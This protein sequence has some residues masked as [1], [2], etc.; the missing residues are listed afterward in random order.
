MSSLPTLRVREK[1]VTTK[2]GGGGRPPVIDFPR[3]GGGGGGGGRDD[4]YPDFGERL[5]RYR[6]GL[7]VGLAA[8]VMLFVSFTS[9][10]IVRQ[11]LGSYDQATQAYVTDWKP[12]SLPMGLLL[13]NTCILLASSFT[14][15]MARRAAFA[16]AA[17]V[18][19]TEMPGIA[20]EPDRGMP[21]LPITVVL[22]FGFLAGQLLAWHELGKRGFYVSSS[23]SSSFFYV[24]T[25]MHG[26]HL[27]GG[28]LALL[29][30]LA[31]VFRSR[32]LER[33]RIV[34]DVTAWYWHFMA[35]LWLYIFALLKFAA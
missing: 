22:G 8:V 12:L 33:K 24:L 4:G 16:K 32:P 21:W 17:I 14:I 3:Y 23:P 2:A 30:A 27:L 5:R 29:Y 15:E 1:P 26:V 25:G 28:A 18:P 13:L 10:Y 35:I 34:V 11:G 31:A 9:A 19:V 20:K 6:L 7:M